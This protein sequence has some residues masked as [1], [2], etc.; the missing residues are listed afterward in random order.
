MSRPRA[1][2]LTG[3]LPWPADD[4]GRVEMAHTVAG[5]ARAWEVTVL[6]MVPRGEAAAAP[7]RVPPELAAR[8][9]RV[10]AIE[11]VPPPT[12]LAAIDGLVGPLPY[13]LARYRSARYAAALRAEVARTGAELV[14][15]NNLHYAQYEPAARPAAFV[16]RQQNLEHV[17]LRRYAR[18]LPWG[19]ARFYAALQS[20]RMR[21]A[22]RR[23]CEAAD[24]V[25]AIQPSEVEGQR[26]L[27]P[28]AWVE[29]LPASVAMDRVPPRAPAAEPTVL[30]CG[31]FGW[32]PNAAGARRFLEHGWDRVRARVPGA[33][34]RLVGKQLPDDLASLARA[35]GADPVGYV[36]DFPPELA[37]A[38]A[39]VVPLWVGAG[40]RIKIV[41]ALAAR[42]PVACTA[43][44]CEG[45][46]VEPGRHAL[47]A[48]TPE[49]LA[50]AVA[51]LLTERSRAE[52]VAE[53][54]VAL[55]RE[56]FGAEAVAQR[57]VE[58]L[59]RAV[60]RHRAD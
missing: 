47:V 38:W 35:H 31:A 37:R 49:A 22:E 6:S 60:A 18:A 39:L 15:A 24:L 28:G 14:V 57:F 59:R 25:L 43:L 16:L 17:W 2:V 34:L 56:Q 53:A 23:L 27:A 21:G 42:T 30:L 48:E 50:D 11:H 36:E 7:G 41:E 58:L 8:G 4:G 45:L 5:V 52:A 40:A 13:T 32:P 29:L 46:G 44:S 3:R 33:R 54:G 1:I 20:V 10:V 26:A 51:T 9:V 55:A 12:V 19:P